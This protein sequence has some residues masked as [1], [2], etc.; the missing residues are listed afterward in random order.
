[1]L[2]GVAV[3]SLV[4]VFGNLFKKVFELLV[5]KDLPL[6]AL[7]K[8]MAY[9]LPFSLTFTIPWGFLTAVLLVFGRLSADN[10]LVSFRMAGM[11]MARICRSVFVLAFSLVAL[12]FWLN[13]QVTPRAQSEMKRAMYDMA[14]ADPMSLFV[15]DEVIS[16]LDGYRIFA[17]A[18]EGDHL[19]NVE[20]FQLDAFDN[21]INYIRADQAKIAYAEATDKLEL[22]LTN[23]MTI[24]KDTNNPRDLGLVRPGTTIG[25]GSQEIDL[26]S[27]RDKSNKFRAS[28]HDTATLRRLL[29]EEGERF[30][31]KERNSLRTE[32]NK[33]YSFSLACFTF[34]L[35]GVPLGVTAQR[36]E[37]SVG[38]AVS[39]VIALIYF[40][41]I[42]VADAMKDKSAAAYLMWLPNIIFAG[43]GAWLFL[44]LSKR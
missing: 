1:M 37:T 41:F 22:D 26:G 13:T 19:I 12:S 23:T 35:I 8:F 38:F 15:A 33:R 40:M 2:M 28:I 6:G 36:R 7:L 18:R 30:N 29:R 16:D 14:I 5:D 24:A 3:L 43:L 10:E 9:I 21:P 31:G 11:S 20:I 17:E 4:F 27:L 25:E 32:I 44:R 34:A 39:L 42:I